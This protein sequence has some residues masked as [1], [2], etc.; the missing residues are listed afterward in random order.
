MAAALRGEVKLELAI[1]LPVLVRLVLEVLRL[2]H[3]VWQE[4]LGG[5]WV[6]VLA[7]ESR[8][9]VLPVESRDHLFVQ[10][11][12]VVEANRATA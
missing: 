3:L 1:P 6:A 8:L 5:R 4:L 10:L 12:V 9:L 11:L 2:G 7:V